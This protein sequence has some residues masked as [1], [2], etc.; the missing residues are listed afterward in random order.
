M[1]QN[2]LLIKSSAQ[3]ISLLVFYGNLTIVFPD[4]TLYVRKN[5]VI[6]ITIKN[7]LAAALILIAWSWK[8]WYGLT[9]YLYRYSVPVRV[10]AC[11]LYLLTYILT[12]IF[13]WSEELIL[14][15]CL[16]MCSL[17]VVAL[18]IHSDKHRIKT[19]CKSDDFHKRR[20]SIIGGCL[21]TYEEFK[22]FDYEVSYCFKDWIEWEPFI[23]KLGFEWCKSPHLHRNLLH[24]P[25]RYHNRMPTSLRSATFS[26]AV[27]TYCWIHKV[28]SFSENRFIYV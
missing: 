22:L 24:L 4:F 1:E 13:L 20:H 10:Y 15:A 5:Y 18:W 21:T 11:S 16:A 27:P 2:I 26:V 6:V 23:S 8:L 7:K 3:N 9:T 25:V 19:P 12:Y 17:I 14:E 28:S